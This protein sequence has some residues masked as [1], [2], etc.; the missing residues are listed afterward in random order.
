M[1]NEKMKK[2]AAGRW[3]PVKNSHTDSFKWSEVLDMQQFILGPV[4]FNILS[5]E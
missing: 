5:N 2:S 1:K 3:Q 4:V